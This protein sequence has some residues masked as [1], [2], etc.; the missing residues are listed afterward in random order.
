MK[1]FAS[2]FQEFLQKIS[3]HLLSRT[4][5]GDFWDFSFKGI[6]IFNPWKDCFFSS[7]VLLGAILFIYKE[8]YICIFSKNILTTVCRFFKKFGPVGFD[9]KHLKTPLL[10]NI[11]LFCILYKRFLNI[12]S[13]QFEVILKFF[14]RIFRLQY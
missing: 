14:L 4:I 8:K 6:L 12:L 2:A 1:F 11:D 3:K 10:P 5:L 7:K 13:N 9:G